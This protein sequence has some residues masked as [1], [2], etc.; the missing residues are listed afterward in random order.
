MRWRKTPRTIDLSSVDPD[1]VAARSLDLSQISE[2]GPARSLPPSNPVQPLTKRET[3]ERLGAR[4]WDMLRTRRMKDLWPESTSSEF[5]Q[6]LELVAR[7]PRGHEHELFLGLWDAGHR[8]GTRQRIEPFFVPREV[9]KDHAYILG[10]S[11]SGKSSHAIPQLLLQLAQ[12]YAWTKPGRVESAPI[13]IID[14]KPEGESFLRTFAE[15]LAGALKRPLRFFS[16]D[17]EYVSLHF[18]PMQSLRSIPYPLERAETLLR[19]LSLIYPEGY[20]ADFFTNEQRVQMI[21]VLYDKRPRSF[22]EL[23]DI[24]RGATQGKSG[25][26]DARGLYSAM[27]ALNVAMHVHTAEQP[28]PPDQVVD[29]DRFYDEE[30][31]LY[32]HLDSRANYLLSRDIGKLMLFSLLATAK[33]RIKKQKKRQ[34]FVFIDEF[35][36]LAARNVVELLQDSR[37]AGVAFILAHQTSDSLR[38][39]DG[40]LYGTLFQNCRFKQ[41]LTLEDKR[42]VELF[43]LISGRRSEIRRGGAQTDGTSQG[44]S[45]SYSS[46]QGSASMTGES[47][48]PLW[49]DVRTSSSHTSHSGS[50]HGFSESHE[51][52]RSQ[53]S[54][55]QETMVA[56]LTPEMLVEVNNTELLSLVH[57]KGTGSDSLCPTRGIPVLVHGLYPVKY[58]EFEALSET[59]WPQKLVHPDSYYEKWRPKISRGAIKA[60][61]KAAGPTPPARRPRNAPLAGQHQDQLRP[62][63]EKLA[64]EMIPEFVSVESLARQC[65]LPVKRILELAGALGVPADRKETLMPPWVADALRKLVESA[66]DTPGQ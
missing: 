38:T 51:K 26:R 49:G 31:I 63:A 1:T 28:L 5:M 42:V 65:G 24:V 56:G 54:S 37:S 36:R 21:E 19:A 45:S 35:Q 44:V 18:D 40:D 4:A 7:Q 34:T 53:T 64:S 25:N 66:G 46:S 10:A 13:L 17:P 62:L 6:Y 27:A 39:R 11:G 12:P 43:E 2:A 15:Q 9:F 47:R 30:E 58:E 60:V 59:P 57:V 14:L 33:Q 61:G 52:S 32:V 55:W 23:V 8:D 3:W 41:C 48:G 50:Q 16:N 20:G 29:F 22:G